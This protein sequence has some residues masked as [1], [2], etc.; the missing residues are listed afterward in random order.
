MPFQKACRAGLQQPSLPIRVRNEFPARRQP[1]QPKRSCH[2]NAAALKCTCPVSMPASAGRDVTTA[3]AG[4]V[5]RPGASDPSPTP[6]SGAPLLADLQNRARSP[7]TVNVFGKP[8]TKTELTAL[9][10]FPDQSFTLGTDLD[11]IFTGFRG[12]SDWLAPGHLSYTVRQVRL[13]LR[14]PKAWRRAAAWLAWRRRL[15][16]A[17]ATAAAMGDEPDWGDSLPNSPTCREDPSRPAITIP[18]PFPTNELLAFSCD[19]R[20]AATRSRLT[21]GLILLLEVGTRERM[22]SAAGAARTDD[23]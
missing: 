18:L 12:T 23:P 6:L 13:E 5:T 3:A 9:D 7:S 1:N 10:V 17:A 14:W 22:R 2:D 19:G 11:F 4:R 8:F 15:G 20:V 16:G 21:N